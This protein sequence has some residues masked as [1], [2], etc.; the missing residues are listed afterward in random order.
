MNTIDERSPAFDEAVG[1]FLDQC[2]L[3]TN[4]CGEHVSYTFSTTRG[5][6]YIKVLRSQMGSTS[7]HAFVRISDGA[8]LYP[9]GC[10]KPF[11]GKDGPNGPRTVRGNI[12]SPQSGREAL[13]PWGVRT[14]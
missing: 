5:P 7:I 14:L 6:R 10:N 2:D 8:I 3:V 13:G 9:A 4:G 12:Y 11:I 1:K